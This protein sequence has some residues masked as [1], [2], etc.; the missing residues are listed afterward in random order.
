MNTYSVIGRLGS[1]AEVK[2]LETQQVLSFSMAIDRSYYSRD[3]KERVERTEWLRVNQFSPKDRNITKLAEV[4]K[5][6]ALV[7]VDGVPKAEAWLDKQSGE[8]K[9]AIS[10]TSKDLNILAFAKVEQKAQEFDEPSEAVK[11]ADDLSKD[12]LPF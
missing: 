10:L 2:Q 9:G 11:A 4:L 8:A 7:Y 12:D 5:K 6:G 1:D 3:K